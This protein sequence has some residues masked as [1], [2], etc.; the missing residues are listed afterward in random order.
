[1]ENTMAITHKTN[2]QYMGPYEV[3]EQT[4]GNSY[5]LQEMDGTELQTAVVA[6]RLIPY[7][8]REDLNVWKKQINER[9]MLQQGNKNRKGGMS[10]ASKKK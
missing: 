3:I 1:M 6:F 5:Q 10:K 2:C 9:K 8:K 7:L 4:K